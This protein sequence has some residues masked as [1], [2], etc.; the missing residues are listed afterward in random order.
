MEKQKVFFIR[1]VF[2]AMI[3]FF[4]FGFWLSGTVTQAQYACNEVYLVGCA[5]AGC[6][7]TPAHCPAATHTFVGSMVNALDG[8]RVGLCIEN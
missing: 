8:W 7:Y 6:N 4:I 2:C 1:T 3:L 5:G